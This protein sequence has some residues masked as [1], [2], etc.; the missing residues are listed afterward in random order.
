[1]AS[2]IICIFP[3]DESTDFLFPI[4]EFLSKSDSFWG[5]R[6]DNNE[7][8]Y[9][10][11]RKKIE[12]IKDENNLI[13]FI[14]H[15]ASNCLYGTPKND[16]KIKLF[17]QSNIGIFANQSVFFLSCR[18]SEFINNIPKGNK[19][20]GIGFGD[21]ITEYREVIAERDTGD[22]S[23][24]ADINID[25]IE[26]FND[27]LVNII[28]DTFKYSAAQNMDL[29]NLFLNLKLIINKNIS[30]ILVNKNIK[31]YRTVADLL[32]DMKWDIDLTKNL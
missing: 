19:V 28:K 5:I 22:S 26:N 27:L 10:F 1:M 29:Y 8:L 11:V 9:Q 12:T 14:G 6:S 20:N 3:K 18:S 16:E 32:V 24:G 7:E 13:V 30:D 31:H 23:F 4:Y 25:V 15:G 2:N 21:I 17:E